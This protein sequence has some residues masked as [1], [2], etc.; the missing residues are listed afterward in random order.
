MALPDGLKELHQQLNTTMN[1]YTYFL[2][3]VSAAAVAY[4]IKLTMDSILSWH[5][6]EMIIRTINK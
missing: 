5:V 4:A 3:T 2:L 6:V 1:K